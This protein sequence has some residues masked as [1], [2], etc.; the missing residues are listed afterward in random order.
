MPTQLWKQ[1]GAADE[2]LCSQFVTMMHQMGRALPRV[3]YCP[4]ARVAGRATGPYVGDVVAAFGWFR[5]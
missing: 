2:P 4:I 1:I 3:Q 5:R